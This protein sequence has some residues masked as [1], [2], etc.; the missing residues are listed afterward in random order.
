M[1]GQISVGF[2]FESG[3]I[4]CFE[5]HT[6]HLPNWLKTSEV[7]FDKNESYIREYIAESNDKYPDS[8]T[9][10]PLAPFGYGL[11]VYDFKGNGLYTRQNYFGPAH[12]FGIDIY[13]QSGKKES[14]RKLSETG[15]LTV[16]LWDTELDNYAP[17]VPIPSL[18]DYLILEKKVIDGAREYYEKRFNG[19]DVFM[20]FEC[21]IEADS[22]LEVRTYDHDQTWVNYLNDLLSAGF[23]ISEEAIAIWNEEEKDLAEAY[24]D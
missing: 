1:G 20:E 2:R 10:M 7:L 13:G 23:E 24:A 9:P 17:A 11:L 14:I 8:F 19:E 12:F 21:H 18:D 3:E 22:P 15:K 16:R 6:N 5:T 4:L